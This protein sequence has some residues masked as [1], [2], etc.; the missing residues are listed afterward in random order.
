MEVKTFSGTV[1]GLPHPYSR[2]KER[3]KIGMRGRIVT[4]YQSK[5]EPRSGS[6]LAK[7]RESKSQIDLRF[8][9]R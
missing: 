9:K 4:W 5:V 8:G 6:K 3:E 2:K 7:V 1:G